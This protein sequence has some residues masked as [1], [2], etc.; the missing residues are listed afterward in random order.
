M[1]VHTKDEIDDK[2]A[3]TTAIPFEKRNKQISGESNW[4][5]PKLEY[6]L[7]TTST[8]PAWLSAVAGDAIHDWT[9]RLLDSF[10]KLDKIG[11]GTYSNVYKARDLRTSKIVALKKVR[12]DFNEPDSVKFM[13]REI[14][15]L[16]RLNHP[17]I[18][19]LEGV[20]TSRMSSSLYLVFEY[21]QHDLS[22]LAAVQGVKLTEPQIKCLIKQLLSGLEHCHKNGVLHRDIKGSDLLINNNGIL[23]I[24]DFGLASF[25]DPQKK[26]PMT[27]R[28]VTLWY[29]PPELLLGATLYGV[30]VDMWSVGCVLAELLAGRPIMPGGTEVEQLDK[31]FKL[32]GSPSDIYWHRYRLPLATILKPSRTYK[33]STTETFKDF[34]SCSLPLLESLLAIDPD[35]RSSAIASLNS[36]FFTTKPY[37]CEPS[38]FLPTLLG[39]FSI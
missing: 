13:T 28:V 1:L 29:R 36:D 32:C 6:S 12:F 17:N 33:R 15:I 35:E 18:I 16:K 2:K 27:S 39:N 5:M 26:Q 31:I 4:E 38:E 23:K 10:K 8:W 34:P 25:Y 30:G 3:L 14:F 11:Q 24:A 20:V 19:K 7:T 37:A 9:P 22:S 21:M